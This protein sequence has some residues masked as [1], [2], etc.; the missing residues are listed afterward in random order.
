MLNNAGIEGFEPTTNGLTVRCS[1]TELYS[2]HTNFSINPRIGKL[3]QH[4][5]WISS[6]YSCTNKEK[7]LRSLVL[8]AYVAGAG[9]EPASLV[10]EA[11]KE[12]LLYPAITGSTVTSNVWMPLIKGQFLFLSDKTRR[13]ASTKTPNGFKMIKI[14]L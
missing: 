14:D 2:L 13:P 6:T 8:R 12:P 9:F 1:T 4:T 10:Y 5:I 3:C 7:H 11:N